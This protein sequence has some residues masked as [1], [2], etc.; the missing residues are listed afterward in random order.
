MNKIIV[1]AAAA[2]AIIGCSNDNKIV[3][4]N[5][6]NTTVFFNFRAVEKPLAAG[7][8]TAT[9]Q[10]I[11]DIPNGTYD[12]SVGA[13]LP[14][15]DSDV[16][17]TPAGGSLTFQKKSTQVLVHFGGIDKNGVYNITFNYS[18]SDPINSGSTVTGP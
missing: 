9:L 3:F 10:P 6:C 4:Q 12:F 5:D 2:L 13:V 17:I 16:T 8:T 15:G 11:T 14:D 7:G 1:L 18:S